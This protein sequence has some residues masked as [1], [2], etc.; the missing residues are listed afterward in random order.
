MNT[1]KLLT[2][3]VLALS[4]FLFTGCPYSNE[5]ALSLP[6]A[7]VPS[8]LFG[9]WEQSDS[10]G[11]KIEIVQGEGNTAA[12]TK[13]TVS[14]GSDPTEEKYVGHLTDINGT[15]F[16]NVSESGEFLSYYFYKMTR[17]GDNKIILSPVTGYI[18]ETFEGSD[19]MKKFFAANMQNSYFFENADETYFKIK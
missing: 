2:I 8:Y 16:L 13:T 19:D 3:A 7:K 10:E 15:L 11:V 14:E 4:T 6:T 12:I 17:E 1:S 9:I 18:R 5:N